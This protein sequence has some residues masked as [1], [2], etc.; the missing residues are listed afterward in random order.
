M[1]LLS[2][3]RTADPTKVRISERQHDEEEPKLLETTVGHVVPLLL[4]APDRSSG[5][6]EAI[7][8]K[9]FNEGEW[10]DY[11]ALGGPTIGGKSQSS[12]QHLFAGA[13]QN[14]KVKGGVMPTLPLVSSSVSTMPK[15][16]G[17]D[18]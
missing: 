16:E 11:G 15:R 3:I 18:H 14:A 10:D 2:F 1:D 6:L 5:E 7:V 9:L 8:E 4:V 17:R 13:V 12:I